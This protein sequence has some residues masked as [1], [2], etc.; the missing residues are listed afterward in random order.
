MAWAK[1]AFP[2]VSQSRD[3]QTNVCVGILGGKIAQEIDKRDGSRTKRKR[4]GGWVGGMQ[5][6]GGRLRISFR[7]EMEYLKKE[8]NERDTDTAFIFALTMKRALASVKKNNLLL[9]RY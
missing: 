2:A 5:D 6:G 9:F 1:F 8:K 7:Q 3:A 4:V